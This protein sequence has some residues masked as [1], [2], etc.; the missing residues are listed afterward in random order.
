MTALRPSDHKGA[1]SLCILVE[2]AVEDRL[3]LSPDSFMSPFF[4]APILRA[5]TT[6]RHV[7]VLDCCQVSF[8][9]NSGYVK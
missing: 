9:S 1:Q 2:R 8:P 5:T 3:S 6:K 7:G 4:T